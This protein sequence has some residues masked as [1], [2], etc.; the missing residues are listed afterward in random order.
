MVE[1][2]SKKRVLLVGAFSNPLAMPIP[3]AKMFQDR[4]FEF[5]PIGN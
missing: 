5:I 4:G 1:E 3:A 2:K